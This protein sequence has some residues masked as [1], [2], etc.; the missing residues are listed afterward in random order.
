MGNIGEQIQIHIMIFRLRTVAPAT[1]SD[2]DSADPRRDDTWRPRGIGIDHRKT[3]GFYGGKPW[4]T[5]GK[6]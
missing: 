1:T 2:L 6:P 5:I 3:K 4:E